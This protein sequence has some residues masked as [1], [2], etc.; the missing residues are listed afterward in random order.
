MYGCLHERV[1]DVIYLPERLELHRP[2]LQSAFPDVQFGSDIVAVMRMAEDIFNYV[3]F[4]CGDAVIRQSLHFHGVGKIMAFPL[5]VEPVQ[6][7]G[8]FLRRL[9]LDTD[10]NSPKMQVGVVLI[11]LDWSLAS[12]SN[13]AC[14]LI[15]A[16]SLG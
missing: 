3:V 7:P 1:P 6:E 16:P 10:E 11:S 9:P 4:L 14:G 2:M 8:E 5:P 15:A 13:L 12:I